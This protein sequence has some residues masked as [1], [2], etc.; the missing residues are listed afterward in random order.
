MLEPVLTPEDDE[1]W[2]MWQ[3]ALLSWARIPSFAA[4]VERSKRLIEQAIA[5]HPRACLMWSGGKDST[6]MTHL[7]RCEM[8]IN[9]PAASEKDD[10]DYPG[11]E[12]YVRR[13]A[14][15]WNLELEIL[16]P[17]TSAIGWLREH[18]RSLSVYDDMHSR[19]SGLSRACFYDL[20]ER[21]S[22]R[23]DLTFLGLRTEE[24]AGRKMNRASRGLLYERKNK[25]SDRGRTWL[26]TPLADWSGRDVMAYAASRDIELL[27]VYRCVALMHRDEPWRIRKS[28][29]IPG[30]AASRGAGT[31]LQRYY[32][33]LFRELGRLFSDGRA[34]L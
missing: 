4:K 26:C 28:W 14:A 16:R 23:F 25:H 3:E 32:P 12:D 29:W 27:P 30:N 10:L 18:G 20:V 33:S 15:S 1:L 31:W 7:V 8:G 24:S 21:H 5:E 9:I 6:V 13:L 19:I 34:A 22:A 2:E 17:P 11:E